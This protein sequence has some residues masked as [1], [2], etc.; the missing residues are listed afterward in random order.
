[1]R[2]ELC[3]GYHT[4]S[5][6]YHENQCS[7]GAVKYYVA[8]FRACVELTAGRFDFDLQR[9]TR[10]ALCEPLDERGMAIFTG[11]SAVSQHC[12]LRLRVSAVR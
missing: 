4:V 7:L 6:F 9:Y 2:A 8:L 11:R 3:R 10:A 12:E 1:M 5:G